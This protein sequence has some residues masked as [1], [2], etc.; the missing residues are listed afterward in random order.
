MRLTIHRGTH[1][2][3]GSCSE[4]SSDS[5]DA[6]LVLD[7]GMPLVNSDGTPFEWSAYREQSFE[8]LVDSGILPSITGLY[9]DSSQLVSAVLLSHAHQD[10]YGFLRFVQPSIPIYMSPGTKALVEASNL[11]LEANVNVTSIKTFKMWRPF[12]V[13][14]FAVTPY[15]MDHSAPDAAAFLIEADRKRIFY[16]GDFRGH[17][18]KRVLFDGLRK[19]PPESIDYLVIEGSMIGREEGLYPDETSVEEALVQLIRTDTKIC[20]VFTS[21]QNLDRIVSI[22]RAAKRSGRTLI[23]DLY[24]AFILEKLSGLSPNIPQFDWEGVRVFFLP[25]HA[26]KLGRLDQRL[27]YR[28]ARHRIRPEDIY[29]EPHNKVVLSKDN[30]FYRSLMAKCGEATAVYSMWHGYLERGTLPEFLRER[31]VQLT[32]IHTSGHAIIEHLK[33]IG[34]AINPKSVV[35]IH[36]FYPERFGDI[37]QNVILVNDRQELV[38]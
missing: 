31:G 36:T 3:G 2:I 8:Q 7:L 10:H 37:L 19:H 12:N 16:T 29:R 14:G 21:S 34:E 17:G 27:L 5:T 25:H 28:Y 24:T 30:R 15:L 38:L 35:P 6:R 33:S 13:S 22:F 32:E 23:L 9:N 18:R 1:E 20:F 4:L 11:F 26:E